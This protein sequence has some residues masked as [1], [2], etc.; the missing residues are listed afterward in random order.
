[1][2]IK[3]IKKGLFIKLDLIWTLVFLVGFVIIVYSVNPFETSVLG[4]ILFYAVLFCLLL[5]ILN[6]IKIFFKVPFRF[7]LIIDVI[8]IIILLIKS[9]S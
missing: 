4:L 1:M 6:L 5:G 8:I 9:L 7:I 3:P 2:Q